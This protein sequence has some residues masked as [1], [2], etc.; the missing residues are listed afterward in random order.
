MAFRIGVIEGDG[1]GPEV[2]SWG[3]KILEAAAKLGN[4]ELEFVKAPVGGTAFLETGKVLP[5]ESL[6]TLR[7]CAAI[8][9]GPMGRPDIDAGTRRARRHFGVATVF[10]AIRQFASRETVSRPRSGQPAQR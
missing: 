9:K 3:V 10:R 7:G 2:I 4:I 6:Q 8:L 5:E 1:V